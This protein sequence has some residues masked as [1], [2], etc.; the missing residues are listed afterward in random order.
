MVEKKLLQENKALA[1]E[2]EELRQRFNQVE[3]EN[4]DLTKR[5]EDTA[6]L[7]Q[8]RQEVVSPI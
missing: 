6:E 5:L 7:D 1:D 2:I 3:R 8:L 4:F